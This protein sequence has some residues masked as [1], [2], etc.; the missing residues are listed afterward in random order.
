MGQGARHAGAYKTAPVRT[1]IRKSK[2]AGQTRTS[3]G[4]VKAS[5]L[6]EPCRANTRSRG[7]RRNR[8]AGSSHQWRLLGALGIAALTSFGWIAGMMLKHPGLALALVMLLAGPQ[9]T[10]AFIAYDC[11]SPNASYEAISLLETE[12]CP[13]PKRDY[14]QPVNLTVQLLHRQEE[15]YFEAVRCDYRVT[16]SV[17][18]CGF[19]SLRYNHEVLAQHQRIDIGAKECQKI[20]DD[21]NFIYHGQVIQASL[22]QEIHQVIYTEGRVKDSGACETKDFWR[23]GRRFNGYYEMQV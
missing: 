1:N 21:G 6:E 18:Q 4:A 12:P 11:G 23:N 13:D 19:D 15:R 7:R 3:E 20:A 8:K 14:R 10:S 9:P 2:A 5:D 17:H 16:I 22:D